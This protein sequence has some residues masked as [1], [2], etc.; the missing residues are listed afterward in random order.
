MITVTRGDCHTSAEA[1]IDSGNLDNSFDKP[2]GVLDNSFDKPAGQNDNSF[3][4]PDDAVHASGVV[5][6]NPRDDLDQMESSELFKASQ[7]SF[8]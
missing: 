4:K 1:I 2:A 7:D 3:D 8:A 6:P 5:S